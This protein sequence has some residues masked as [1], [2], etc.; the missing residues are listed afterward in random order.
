MPEVAALTYLAK[1]LQELCKGICFIPF[2]ASRGVSACGSS[3][4]KISL[5]QIAMLTEGPG[6]TENCV[7]GLKVC[8]EKTACPM[9]AKWLPIKQEIVRLLQSQTLDMLAATVTSG[10][11]QLTDFPEWFWVA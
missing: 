5:M 8:S 10:K 11:Y 7:L 3:S 6:F 4:D 2:V 1:I 9:H